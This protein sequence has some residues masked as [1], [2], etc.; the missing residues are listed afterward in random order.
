MKQRRIALLLGQELGYCRGVLSGILD[1]AEEHHMDWSFRDGPSHRSFSD[2]LLHWKP[3]GII[4]HVF[5]REFA[6]SLQDFGVPVVNVTLTIGE[7]PFPVVDVD[8][9]EVGRLAAQYFLK[10]GYHNF[11]YFGSANAMFSRLRES[12]FS[13]ILR[14]RNIRVSCLHDGFVR[15]TPWNVDWDRMERSVR[16]WMKTLQPPV[17]ILCSN[18]LPGRHLAATCRHL[19]Y[20][21]PQDVCIL[22]VDNDDSECRMATPPLSSIALP[23]RAIGFQAGTI[24]HQ[25][26]HSKRLPAPDIHS[27]PPVGIIER[28]STDSVLCMEPR[29]E[30]T[31]RWMQSHAAESHTITDIASANQLSRRTLERL[32]AQ[33]LHM[34]PLQYLTQC[35]IEHAK[36]L[37]R[38]TSHSIAQIGELCGF[39]SQRSFNQHFRNIEHLTPSDYRRFAQSK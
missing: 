29:L 39:P 1:F 24:L 22:G 37:L 18:D 21:I 14:Q 31:L 4:A 20:R 33:V 11:G 13:E 10:L 7:L 26:F 35:R 9:S 15:E 8:H 6:L 5:D 38:N 3:D 27:I 16:K 36:A 30:R 28:Q 12:G 19:G 34:T 17:A 23:T 2:S 25:A 32:F